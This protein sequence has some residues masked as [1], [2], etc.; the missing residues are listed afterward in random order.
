[1]QA[2]TVRDAHSSA[3]LRDRV[4]HSGVNRCGCAHGNPHQRVT[5]LHRLACNR[6][7]LKALTVGQDDQAHQALALARNAVQIKLH[8]R[9]TFAHPCAFLHQQGKAFAIELHGVD[10]HMHQY[11]GTVISAD[12]QGVPGARDVDDHAVT[13]RLQAIVQRVDSDTVAHGAAGEHFVGDA[14]QGQH[15]PT[16]G[17]AKGQWIIVVGHGHGTHQ[18]NAA[19]VRAGDFAQVARLVRVHAPC[20]SKACGHH[21]E[22]LDSQDRVQAR[23]FGAA[24]RHVAFGDIVRRSQQHASTALAHIGGQAQQAGL[25]G[26]AGANTSRG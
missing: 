18:E 11:F 12:G 25:L 15:R 1:M 17:G 16:Q 7:Q 20:L 19:L 2:A 6:L 13:G 24:Q 23:V 21:V 14:V 26:A 8:Q 10:A 4:I 3:H 9:L 22:A 5:G